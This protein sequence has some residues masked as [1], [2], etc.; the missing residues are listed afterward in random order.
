MHKKRTA[1]YALRRTLPLHSW[2]ANLE[3]LLE[4]CPKYGIDE[5]ILKVDTECLSHNLPTV[6]W[7]KNY[8]P[9]MFEIKHE[10]EKI[11][12]V[13][14]LNPWVTT[15]HCDRGR[16]LSSRFSERDFMVGH[17]GVRCKACLAHSSEAWR[18]ETAKLWKIY[19]ETGP[20]VLWVEDDLRTFNHAPILYSGFD[21]NNLEKFSG[22]IGRKVSR[23]ELVMAILH[24]GKPHPWRKIWF[25]IL[26][27]VV[28]EACEN[29]VK[30][31]HDINPDISFGLMSSGPANHSLEGRDWYELAGIFSDK[32]RLKLY[33]RPPLSN[34]SEKSLRGLYYSADSIRWT[35]SMFPR[36]IIEQ[37]E[38]ENLPFFHYSKSDNFTF[39]QMALSFALGCQGAT[40]NLFDHL[41]TPMEYC[42][43]V[44]KMLADKKNYLNSI[45]QVSDS[46]TGKVR[47]VRLLFSPESSLNKHLPATPSY[48]DLQCRSDMWS[49]ILQGMGFGITFSEESVTA[50]SGQAIRAF[51]KPAIEKI[52][53]RGVLCDL[54]A[55]IA[56][57]DMGYSEA[58]GIEFDR[59]LSEFNQEPMGAEEFH[60]PEF[61]GSENCLM[62]TIFRFN[63][64]YP[65]IPTTGVPRLLPGAKTISSLINPDKERV[66]P[67]ATVCEN[68]FGGRVAVIPYSLN[69]FRNG[70]EPAFCNPYRKIM[71]KKLLNWLAGTV[72]PLFVDAQ[73]YW[74]LPFR[75]DYPDYTIAALFNLNLD[76][77]PESSFELSWERGPVK[78]ITKLSPKGNWEAGKLEYEFQ[79]H[80]LKIVNQK[81]QKFSEPLFILIKF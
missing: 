63:D 5:V 45:A 17:D 74:T 55:A 4:C 19:A 59:M 77:I 76:A 35:R 34:Y 31:V 1:W 18:E 53:Y 58:I 39:L 10:L 75:I 60:N 65:E 26:R 27:D 40:L 6:E 9:I 70:I 43:S 22:I 57:I 23:E 13:Y 54:D 61:G 68:E 29:I 11:A 79:N 66:C 21:A 47:G 46:D 16:D 56:L 78:S 72:P 41:G 42:P 30:A 15:V 71:F 69:M 49:P 24:P 73:D 67:C 50:L 37:A 8:Q 12:V 7:L 51:S 14:S 38:V 80:I 33:S 3:E 32:F 2:K 28:L 25:E 48:H 64:T 62:T 52:L 36:G 20:R 44:G 81:P